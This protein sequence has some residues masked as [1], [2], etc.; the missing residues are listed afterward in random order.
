MNTKAWAGVA[1]I[2]VSYAGNC[3]GAIN[4]PTASPSY[5][6]GGAAP[7]DVTISAFIPDGNLIRNS[8]QLFQLNESGQPIAFLGNLNDNGLNGDA[9]AEDNVFTTTV[10]VSAT[11][12][13]AVKLRISAALLRTIRRITIDTEIVVINIPPII[14]Y[15]QYNDVVNRIHNA[16]VEAGDHF[17]ALDEPTS[18]DEFAFHVGAIRD[19]FQTIYA[20]MEAIHRFE[21]HSPSNYPA[22]SEGSPWVGEMFEGANRVSGEE[23]RFLNDPRDPSVRAVRDFCADKLKSTDYEDFMTN[24]ESRQF[25][26][27][28]SVQPL[29]QPKGSSV[30]KLLNK[31]TGHVI[32][33]NIVHQF[34]GLVPGALGNIFD[35]GWLGVKAVGAGLDKMV[36]FFIDEATGEWGMVVGSVAGASTLAL[37]AGRHDIIFSHE[38][39]APRTIVREIAVAKDITTLVTIVPGEVRDTLL[40]QE[41]PLD[42]TVDLAVF[43]GGQKIQPYGDVVFPGTQ[44]ELRANLNVKGGDTKDWIESGKDTVETDFYV[45]IG[46]GGWNRIGREYTRITN[47]PKGATHTETL[48][49]AIP[50]TG[51]DRVSFRVR[52]D[53]TGEVLESEEGEKNNTKE[54]GSFWT[55]YIDL[56]GDIV[57]QEGWESA[58]L[59]PVPCV[60]HSP[61]IYICSL[62]ADS[63]IWSMSSLGQM[64]LAEILPGKMIK[65]TSEGM[66]GFGASRSLNSPLL[67]TT[68]LVFDSHGNDLG[69]CGG[70]VSMTIYF[71]LPHPV[72]CEETINGEHLKADSSQITYMFDHSLSRVLPLCGALANVGP[73]E[74]FQANIFDEFVHYL[75]YDPNGVI[76]N[77]IELRVERAPCMS[78]PPPPNAAVS[79]TWDN[80]VLRK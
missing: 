33:K 29:Q 18:A 31:D 4:I 60:Q 1:L 36:D 68:T 67:P 22:W 7:K 70:V 13:N 61:G 30:N 76:V 59:G 52:I 21:T 38:E 74:W 72:E 27:N 78:W 71:E 45:K 6:V 14:E 32:V 2:I 54:S 42:L 39:D 16:L 79:A 17:T 24:L 15:S 56:V 53:A 73:V 57:F 11:S 19:A 49:Y 48:V 20:N 77:R 44:V 41:S 80:I 50:D 8:V 58:P 65:L 43:N 37:P 26:W 10:P 5:I 55:K 75:P 63:G 3:I 34:T 28:Y 12:Q 46:K 25:C 66:P 47:L 69:P 64:P 51:G 23:A 40:R 35:W 9:T 62:E